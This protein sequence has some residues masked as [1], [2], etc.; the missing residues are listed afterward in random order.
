MAPVAL[1]YCAAGN[2]IF[3]RAALAAGWL[4]GARL[5]DWYDRNLPLYFAD[6]DWRAPNRAAYMIALARV[7]PNMATVL[8]LEYPEQGAEVLSWAKEAAEYVE[9][10]VIVPKVSGVID[11]LPRSVGGAAVVLG[12]S[13]P[14]SYGGT[15][16]PVWEFQGWPVH[17]L[18]GSPQA[19]RRLSR[20]LNVISLDGSMMQQQAMRGRFWSRQSS[21]RYRS[22]WWQLSEAGDLRTEGVPLECF[23]R[24]LGAVHSLW[25]SE[26]P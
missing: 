18:G 9:R 4:Y 1:I 20:Y 15:E 3:A 7:R 25:N 21:P 23:R 2:P 10:V 12:F 5:P 24:S 26:Q 22:C 16:V 19:Q 8:D 14:T 13:V 17:L 11:S 6:Q